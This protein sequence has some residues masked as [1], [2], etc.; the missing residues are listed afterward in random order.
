[1]KL[2]SE[3]LISMW[4]IKRA[5]V[6][7]E[8]EEKGDAWSLLAL[9]AVLRYSLAHPFPSQMYPLRDNLPGKLVQNGLCAV[10]YH[11]GLENEDIACL[12]LHTCVQVLTQGVSTLRRLIALL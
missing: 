5:Y 9:L 3:Y 6:Y 8:M 2:R 11:I 12:L 10:R 7:M 4:A 1:M